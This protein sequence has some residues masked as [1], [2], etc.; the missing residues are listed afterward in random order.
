M[1]NAP[2]FG[3]FF[4]ATTKIDQKF[5][6]ESLVS[7]SHDID[8]LKASLP[9]IAHWLKVTVTNPELPP[10]ICY[11]ESS[12]NQKYFIRQIPLIV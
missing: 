11:H 6:T 1:T 7:A 3:L 8:K 2:M 10:M 9:H 12:T 5:N 4:V